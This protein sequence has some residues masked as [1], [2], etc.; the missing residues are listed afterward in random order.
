MKNKATINNPLVQNI[1]TLLKRSIELLQDVKEHSENEQDARQV[2]DRELLQALN[3]VTPLLHPAIQEQLA[4]LVNLRNE[5]HSP[6][7]GRATTITQLH[8]NNEKRPDLPG[9]AQPE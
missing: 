1:G 9:W 5:I 7:L 6:Y 4:Q 8:H 2:A 3:T